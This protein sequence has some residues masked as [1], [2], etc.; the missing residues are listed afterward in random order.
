MVRINRDF[1]NIEMGIANSFDNYPNSLS[2]QT[3]QVRKLTA[4]NDRGYIHFGVK[5]IDALF[6]CYVS[7]AS[8][9]ANYRSRYCIW[10][11]K[12]APEPHKFHWR[13]QPYRA[14]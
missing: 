10:N 7:S 3:C 13:F 14:P 4:I 6:S 8:D 1:Y 9:I 5:L 2:L 11:G 12:L